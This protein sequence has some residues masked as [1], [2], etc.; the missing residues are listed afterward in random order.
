MFRTMLIATALLLA[1]MPLFAATA[2]CSTSIEGSDA[3]KYNKSEIEISKS[4]KTFTVT[5]KHT[6]KFEKEDM[7]HNFVVASGSDQ[8]GILADGLK[9]GLDASFIK[10][11]DARVIAATKLVG[12]GESASTI[13]P[14]AK[15]LSGGPY[16]F[17]CSFPG[18]A[19]M[20]K[21][22]IKLVP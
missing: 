21:G 2:A 15:L 17:F 20:M 9:A 4:C 6:G 5:L 10:A 1:P 14:V 18:H 7:G 3:M 8:A 16:V 22:T 13:V 12:G 11:G 19:S